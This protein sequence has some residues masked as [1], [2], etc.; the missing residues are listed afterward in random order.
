MNNKAHPPFPMHP[1]RGLDPHD[2]F[3]PRCG[4]PD[5]HKTFGVVMKTSLTD[6]HKVYASKGYEQQVEE[7]LAKQGKLALIGTL[8]WQEV[9]PGAPIPAPHMCQDCVIVVRQMEQDIENGGV[10]FACK[11][12]GMQGII[13]ADTHYAKEVRKQHDLPA[14]APVKVVFNTCADHVNVFQPKKEAQDED[15]AEEYGFRVL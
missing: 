7:N 12:C 3:C 4:K 6:G 14:P 9:V 5:G 13:K 11:Q 8:T 10:F 1:V 15:P 2:T